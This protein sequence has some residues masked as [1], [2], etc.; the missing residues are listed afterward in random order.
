TSLLGDL[1]PIDKRSR[2][3][4]VFMLGL[5]L[6]LGLSYLISGA[7]AQRWGWRAALFV[8]GAPGAFLGLLM[9]WVPE[10]VRGASESHI[11]APL[12]GTGEKDSQEGLS[13]GSGALVG[14]IS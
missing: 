9:L 7:I 2:T 1:F 6:G 3:M 11:P 8:A 13:L 10:P 14:R 4:A 12:P 5:P